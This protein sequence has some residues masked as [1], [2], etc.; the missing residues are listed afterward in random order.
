[1]TKRG[2]F[3]G[4]GN[5]LFCPDDTMTK[6]EFITVVSRILYP[7][8]KLSDTPDSAWWM[9]DYIKLTDN[10]VIDYDIFEL[11]LDT[12]MS[13]EEMAY[14]AVKAL[15]ARGEDISKLNGNIIIPD[16]KSISD[17]FVEYVVIAYGKGIIAG[18]EK[19]NF[20]LQNTL[21]RAEASTVLYRL[22]ETS[23]RVIPDKKPVPEQTD[24]IINKDWHDSVIQNTGAITIK[25]YEKSVR[26]L[27]IFF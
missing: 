23:A 14:V 18:D 27:A 6:A 19:G 10:K 13:R 22:I 8:M 12:K 11:N 5:N 3:N 16:S 15:V 26:R 1:M 9:N 25:E 20:N 21:T 4:K 2:L 7:D 24:K 17:F